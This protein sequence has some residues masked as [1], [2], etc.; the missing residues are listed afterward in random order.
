MLLYPAAVISPLTSCA[1][2]A[3]QL[4]AGCWADPCVLRCYGVTA[5]GHVCGYCVAAAD[6]WVDS[7]L[8]TLHTSTTLQTVSS[9]LSRAALL[10]GG[11]GLIFCNIFT[12]LDTRWLAKATFMYKYL[13]TWSKKKNLLLTELSFTTTLLNSVMAQDRAGKTSGW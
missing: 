11:G 9:G 12:S 4:G 8:T 10:S 2:R 13:P 7:A 3:D 5:R 6:A 1:D